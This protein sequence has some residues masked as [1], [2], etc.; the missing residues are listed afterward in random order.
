MAAINLTPNEKN[1]INLTQQEI[2]SNKRKN[3]TIFVDDSEDED[4]PI[5]VIGAGLAGL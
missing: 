5:L 1:D 2:S 3:L 4:L